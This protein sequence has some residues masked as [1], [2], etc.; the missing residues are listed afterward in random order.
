MSKEEKSLRETIDIALDAIEELLDE[1]WMLRDIR[2]KMKKQI[3]T[4]RNKLKRLEN[5]NDKKE[6]DDS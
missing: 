3:R 4:L 2:V 5:K 1:I 6:D